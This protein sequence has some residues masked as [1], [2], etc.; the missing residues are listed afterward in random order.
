MELRLTD[1]ILRINLDPQ[2]GLDFFLKFFQMT[3][4]FSGARTFSINRLK[5]ACASISVSLSKY[6]ETMAIFPFLAATYSANMRAEISFLL[7]T[8]TEEDATNPMMSLVFG[9]AIANV[10]SLSSFSLSRIRQC[11]LP[12]RKPLETAFPFQLFLL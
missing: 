11:F 9:T 8:S 6:T 2:F 10:P 12:P 5:Y 4:S 7:P 3:F 1:G